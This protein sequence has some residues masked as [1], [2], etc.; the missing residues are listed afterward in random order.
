[1][2][3]VC[4]V[5]T[6]P[7]VAVVIPVPVVPIV[8][9][10]VPVPGRHIGIPGIIGVRVICVSRRIGVAV[11]RIAVVPVVPAVIG[12]T[13]NGRA[14]YCTNSKTNG[15]RIT[16]VTRLTWRGCSKCECTRQCHGCCVF[17]DRLHWTSFQFRLSTIKRQPGN[18][19]RGCAGTASSALAPFTNIWGNLQ[20]RLSA[21]RFPNRGNRHWLHRQDR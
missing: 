7:V 14:R 5:L 17:S 9:V 15:G 16:P 18:T 13:G 20:R 4:A 2:K 1:R 6:G 3:I 10:P 8:T 12:R 19:Q 21:K 11:A